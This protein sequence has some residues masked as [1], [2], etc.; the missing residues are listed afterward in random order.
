VNK[1][2]GDSPDKLAAIFISIVTWENKLKYLHE[3]R[4]KEVIRNMLTEY[5]T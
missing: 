1:F 3:A 2:W 4:K 5:G